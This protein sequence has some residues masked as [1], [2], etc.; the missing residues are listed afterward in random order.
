MAQSNNG[1]SFWLRVAAFVIDLVIPPAIVLVGTFIFERSTG[2]IPA[3][4]IQNVIMAV[5]LYLYHIIFIA[6][7][8][9]TPGKMLLGLRVVSVQ[10]GKPN[11]GQVLLRELIGKTIA[12]APIFLGLL[13]ALWDQEKRGWHDRIGGTLV[14]RKRQ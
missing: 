14:V 13:W 3:Q 6:A 2:I 5:A 12:A 7:L 1:A 11:F 4:V 8:G 10:G 9:R